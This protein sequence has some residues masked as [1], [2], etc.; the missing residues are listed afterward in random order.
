MKEALKMQE[1]GMGTDEILQ[2]FEKT[3]RTKNASGGI[4]RLLGE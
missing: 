1:K 3:P 4:A 2:T